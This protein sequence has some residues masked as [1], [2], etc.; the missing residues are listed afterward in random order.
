MGLRDILNTEENYK[1]GLLSNKEALQ[2]F[3]AKLQK[4]Q[5]D[6]ENG[7]ENYKKPTIEV[8]QSTLATILSYQRDILLATY[9]SGASL[10]AF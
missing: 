3:Q 6:L 9:S 10:S 1:D 5:S 2:Y 8:Y 4:I 7:I